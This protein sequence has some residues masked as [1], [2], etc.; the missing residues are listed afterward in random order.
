MTFPGEIMTKTIREFVLK[1]LYIIGG[2]ESIVEHGR[3]FWPKTNTN[4]NNNNEKPNPCRQMTKKTLLATALVS[5]TSSNG[6]KIALKA[7]IDQ[8]C[9]NAFVS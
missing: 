9:Q 7:L 3:K 2:K 1:Y 6:E 4:S 5:A 8:E